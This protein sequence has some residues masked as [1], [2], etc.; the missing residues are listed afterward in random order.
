M[1]LHISRLL[2]LSFFLQLAFVLFSQE[3]PKHDYVWALG[4]GKGFDTSGVGGFNL[5]F[6]FSP[7]Q[8]HFV[9]RN[10]DIDRANASISDEEGNLIFYTNGCFIA[11]RNNQLMP[12]GDSLNAGTQNFDNSCKPHSH[13]NQIG[14]YPGT[15]RMLILPQPGQTGRYF[16]FHQ[17]SN[18]L[19]PAELVTDRLLYTVVDMSL[20]GGLGEVVEKNVPAISDILYPGHLT[21]VKH[22]NGYD[23]WIVCAK[24]LSNVY[25][26]LLL[27]ENGLEGPF[28]QTIGVPVTKPGEG[29]GQACFSPDGTTYVRYN[30]V[31]HLFIMDFDRE[32]GLFSNFKN[33]ILHLGVAFAGG[34]AFSPNS[35]YLYVTNSLYIYQFDM[36]DL[37]MHHLVAE[38]NGLANPYPGYFFHAQL[39][40]DC[41]I[42]INTSNGTRYLHVIHKPD[43]P[44]PQCD[45]RQHDVILP[46]YN[47]I[48][49][50]HF[51]NY[52]LG[53]V[54]EP[55][56]EPVLDAKETAHAAEA[57]LLYPN[58]ARGAVFIR[59]PELKDGYF[60][61]FNTAGQAI[62]LARLVGAEH[63]LTLP[64]LP[65]GIYFYEITE[66]GMPA[67]RGKLLLE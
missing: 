29:S 11:D 63:D 45:V 58:P 55:P 4:Y 12:N 30:K 10:M 51:P 37:F 14:G 17:R 47:F 24:R 44:G 67:G 57:F 66:N 6:N 22:A 27:T 56:C 34:V 5:D 21:A 1:H 25:Y 33:R 13:N 54:P 15:Q 50:S 3:G 26:T 32:Q 64:P 48:A 59:S 40:P 46:T 35:R 28:E 9:E 16:V 20:N 39:G 53:V 8:A 31:Q 36:E 19:P 38:Y 42:Y 62:H 61:L 65:A 60:R 7:P 23:W 18:Y 52:R 43:L 49:L 41:K 2:F